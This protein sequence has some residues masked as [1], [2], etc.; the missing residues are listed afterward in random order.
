MTTL[1]IFF[2][3]ILELTNVHQSP[4]QIIFVNKQKLEH[5]HVQEINVIN[6]ENFS[7]HLKVQY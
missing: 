4:N 7:Q 2:F 1:V 6:Y 3:Y 5:I